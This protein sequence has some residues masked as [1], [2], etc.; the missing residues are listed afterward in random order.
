MSKL[1]LTV[2]VLLQKLDTIKDNQP[3]SHPVWTGIDSRALHEPAQN[4]RLYKKKYTC[5]RMCRSVQQF[6]YLDCPLCAAFSVCVLVCGVKPVGTAAVLDAGGGL[7][8]ITLSFLQLQLRAEYSGTRKPS[9]LH[10]DIS[11]R[12]SETERVHRKK[13]RLERG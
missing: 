8:Q 2:F 10:A 12:K 6:K 9:T 5:G 7:N 11:I 4:K 3:H 13:K 1:N